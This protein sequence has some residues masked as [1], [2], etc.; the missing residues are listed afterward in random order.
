[1][2]GLSDFDVMVGRLVNWGRWGRQD[3]DKP[4][5]NAVTGSIYGMGRADRQGEGDSGEEAEGPMDPIDHLDADRLDRMIMRLAVAHRRSVSCYFYRRA[6]VARMAVDEA[7]RA[8]C[9]ID[10]GR[11]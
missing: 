11:R 3:T 1:M 10:E 2:T 8:L 4:D 6:P 7:I 5:A 9:D